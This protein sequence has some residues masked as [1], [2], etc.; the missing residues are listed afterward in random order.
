MGTSDV[1][2]GI[3][4]AFKVLRIQIKTKQYNMLDKIN[5]NVSQIICFFVFL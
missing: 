1:V 5:C 3:I 2:K 4:L